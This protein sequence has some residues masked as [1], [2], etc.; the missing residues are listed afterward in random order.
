MGSINISYFGV[1]LIFASGW[2]ILGWPLYVSTIYNHGRITYKFTLGASLVGIV[3]GICL[4]GIALK[5]PPFIILFT[6]I[7]CGFASLMGLFV[8]IRKKE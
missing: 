6:S 3:I 4:V 7:F 1:A 5:F 8:G 2:L